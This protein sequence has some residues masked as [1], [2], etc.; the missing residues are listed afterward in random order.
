MVLF[1]VIIALTVFTMVAFSLVMALN[2][3]MNAALQRNA[4]DAA[5]LGLENQR[6][7]LHASRLIPTDKDLPD[8]GSGITYHLLVEAAQMQDQKKQ[9]VAGI[10]RA[11]I[12]AKWGIGSH[13]QDR[14]I[15]E[16]MYQP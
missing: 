6:A 1:E 9:P 16:L 14:T 13:A 4:I 7:M 12:T 15:T 5:T 10:Y 3:A 2:M 8:D 11:T